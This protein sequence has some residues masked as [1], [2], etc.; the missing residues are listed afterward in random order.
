MV[1]GETP[2]VRDSDD[3]QLIQ[4]VEHKEIADSEAVRQHQV[5]VTCKQP[6][7]VAGAPLRIIFEDEPLGLLRLRRTTVSFNRSGHPGQYRL[8]GTGR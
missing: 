8:N 6:E 3:R 1:L 2:V 7:L 4:R 5:T